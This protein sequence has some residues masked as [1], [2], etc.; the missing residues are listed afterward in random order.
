MAAT[1]ALRAMLP[2]FTAELDAVEPDL[3]TLLQRWFTRS[4]KDVEKLAQQLLHDETYLQSI[5]GFALGDLQT[6]QAIEAL[7]DALLQ[8]V[9]SAPTRWAVAE[10][11]LLLDPALVLQRAILPF[12]D[13][14]LAR[15]AGVLGTA[16]WKKRAY[17][18]PHMA[19]LIGRTRAQHPA[20]EAFLQRC[21][22]EWHPVSYKV[23][24]I[25][26]LGWMYDRRYKEPFE[27]IAAGQ[28][29]E[30]AL[31][32]S[33]SPQID[34]ILLQCTALDALGDIGDRET[35]DRIRAAM[36]A[37]PK[38][39]RNRD[40]VRAFYHATEEIFWRLELAADR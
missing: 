4:D 25:R 2:Q 6:P 35:V 9:G 26:A 11:M 16:A 28:F 27:R 37:D 19:Y 34:G 18:Y 7:F 8:R 20:T 17:W 39:W 40:L 30:L 29:D 21:L 15:Q 36:R 22:Y 10:A 14:D 12:L 23:Q 24:A 32:E 13:E 38:R 3:S 1:L 5:A 33:F 31:G